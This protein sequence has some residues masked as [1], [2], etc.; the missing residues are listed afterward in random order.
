[1]RF[2]TAVNK[3]CWQAAHQ[4]PITVWK[5]ALYQ[6]RPYLDVEDATRFIKLV[7]LNDVEPSLYNVVTENLTVS[8][9]IEE[10]GRHKTKIDIDYVD[11]EIMNQLSYEV[12][13]KKSLDCGF[14][15]TGSVRNGITETLNLFNSWQ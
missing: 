12:S 6:K 2:H 9:L 4:T 10:I 8:D 15:Y 1:M 11:S 13:S 3:F 5:T 7:T 14:K